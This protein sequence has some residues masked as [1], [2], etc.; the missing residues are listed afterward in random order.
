[1][2]IAT[3]ADVRAFLND[4][5]R[6]DR[7]RS[8]ISNRLA[9]IRSF[10]KYVKVYHGFPVPDLEDIDLTDYPKARWEEQCQEPLTRADVRRLIETPKNLRDALIIGFLYYSG[11]RVDEL[12][13]LTLDSVDVENRILEVV[14]KGNKPRKVPYSSK[15]DCAI[16]Y[17]LNHV[18]ISYVSHD[19]LFFFPSKNGFKLRTNSVYKMVHKAA[20]KAGI[21]QIVGR[22]ADGSN[23]YRVHPHTLRHS[24]AHHAIDDDISLNLLQK[25]MGHSSINMTIRY[26]GESGIFK[27]YYE[28]FRGI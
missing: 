26:A 22:R 25:M 11:L 15:L 23:I 9:A 13:S 5:K 4:L 3:K 20:V 12:V 6:R 8:T 16:R 21:Q 1:M 27:S 18:R 19:G 7:A 17:W 10:Y 24:Y 28:K 14:G 2:I